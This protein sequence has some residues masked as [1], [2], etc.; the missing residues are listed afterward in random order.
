MQEL[1]SRQSRGTAP[2]AY[3]VLVGK[4]QGT[5]SVGRPRCR[6]DSNT[7]MDLQKVEQGGMG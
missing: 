3:R 1:P 2:D 6:W 5:R 7:K 4:L